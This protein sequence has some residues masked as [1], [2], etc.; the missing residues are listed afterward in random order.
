MELR[1]KRREIM[2][3]RT[4]IMMGGAG[5][6]FMIGRILIRISPN[7]SWKGNGYKVNIF[8]QQISHLDHALED[9]AKY[10]PTHRHLKEVPQLSPA[11]FISKY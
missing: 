8:R 1:V 6:D 10:P 4:I 7:A 9:I 2:G 11:N 3:L 5:A